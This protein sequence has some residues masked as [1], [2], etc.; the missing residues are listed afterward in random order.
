MQ[1]LNK[2][3]ELLKQIQN[4]IHPLEKY[5]D[6]NGSQYKEQ[7]SDS[8]LLKRLLAEGLIH[9]EGQVYIASDKLSITPKGAIELFEWES[10]IE[11]KSMLHKF[12][13]ASLNLMWLIVGAALT[14]L[15]RLNS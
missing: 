3:I 11:E 15:V 6:G 10:K 7:E 9:S 2:Y 8:N 12:K 14:Y 4:D 1:L 5:K 13:G